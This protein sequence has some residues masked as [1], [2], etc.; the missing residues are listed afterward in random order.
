MATSVLELV[1]QNIYT[2]ITDLATDAGDLVVYRPKLADF[3]DVAVADL[4]TVM[5]QTGSE[6]P[7]ATATGTREQLQTF[8]ITT[9]VLTESDTTDSLD[10]RCNA[11]Y[12]ALLAALLTDVT[13][14][15]YA[16]N[17]VVGYPQFFK[18]PEQALAGVTVPV[19]VH[20]RT[21]WNSASTQA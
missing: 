1:A 14:G 2:T 3:S 19:Q 21:T 13:R 20:Y 4:T 18:I 9:Y 11:V 16:L 7:E 15:G 12:T 10:T 8:E 5:E 6:A 17:T